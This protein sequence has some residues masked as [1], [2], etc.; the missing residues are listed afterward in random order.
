MKAIPPLVCSAY[1]PPSTAL[2]QLSSGPFP[3][4][5]RNVG[6]RC[7]LLASPLHTALDLIVL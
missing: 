3:E 7:R 4:H 2:A 1:T 6:T 5:G